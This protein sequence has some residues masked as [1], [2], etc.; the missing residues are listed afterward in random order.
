MEFAAPPGYEKV[1]PFD[2]DLHGHLSVRPDIAFNFARN[3]NAIYVTTT[4]ML[5]AAHDYPVVFATDVDQKEFLPITVT[6]FESGKNLFVDE[7]GNWKADT[8][9]PAYIRRY[10][11]CVAE[12]RR[13]ESGP[14]ESLICVD[15]SALEESDKGFFD[16]GGKPSDEWTRIEQFIKDYEVARKTTSIVCRAIQENN[17]LEVFEAQAFHNEGQQYNL[18]NMHR[19]NEK[20]LSKLT[21]RVLKEFIEKQYMF[22]VYAHLMSLENFQRLLGMTRKNV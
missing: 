2:K 17:L 12:V 4:E 9:I 22:V 11:F 7:A 21:A 5:Q 20:K 15:E 10:P 6:G 16:A 8:Y 19:V 18:K 1:V 13:S 3:L 14:L